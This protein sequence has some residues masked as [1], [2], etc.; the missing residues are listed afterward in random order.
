MECGPL[1]CGTEIWTIG[2]PEMYVMIRVK[3][4]VKWVDKVTNFR[5]K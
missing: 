2:M 3:V 5:D 1:E 4:K